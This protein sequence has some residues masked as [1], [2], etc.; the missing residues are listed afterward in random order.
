MSRRAVLL[1]A[2]IGADLAWIVALRHS[3]L[4]PRDAP[5]L[6]GLLIYGP[7]LA[8]AGVGLAVAL[9]RGLFTAA[10]L[11]LEAPAWT[12]RRGHIGR[13]VLLLA[14]FLAGALVDMSGP[15]GTM[16]ANGMSYDQIVAHL[17]SHEYRY[18][19]GTREPP[20]ALVDISLRAAKSCILAPLAEEVP[21]RA[22][23]IPV[24]LSRLSRQSAALASGAMFFLI[25]WL[26][27]GAEPHPAYFLSGW[28]FAW[29]FMLV[30]LSGSLA[31]HAGENFGVLALAIFA[32]FAS[33]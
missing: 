12:M 1:L 25:H 27:Y 16:I 28:V 24:V 13:V 10:E 4:E 15:L 31:A 22:L 5:V 20:I 14:I 7:T 23:F 6:R 3:G 17:F 11:G 18:M 33:T 21:Y 9:R 19:F 29:A 26:V 2:I 8:I 32:A 30:G